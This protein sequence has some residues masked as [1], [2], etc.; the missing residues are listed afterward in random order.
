[1]KIWLLAFAF[2]SL[3]FAFSS[4]SKLN[5]SNLDLNNENL[6][7]VRNQHNIS[8]CYA[9]TGADMLAHE[10]KVNEAISAADVAI[11][12]N[13]TKIALFVRWLD[14]NILNRRDS[15][16][17]SLA[18]QNGFNKVALN[19]AMKDGWCPESI[20]PSEAWPKMSRTERGWVQ[21]QIPLDQAMLEIAALHEKNK[22]LTV[23]NIP[24]YFNLK[25]IDLS[26]FLKILQSKSM[27]TI[28]SSI[29]QTVCRD[30]RHPFEDQRNIKMVFKNSEI[31][32]TIG[33]QLEVGKLVGLDYDSRILKDRNHTGFELNNL[34][35]SSLVG[36]RWNEKKNTCEYLIRNS[37]GNACGNR[38]DPGYDCIS[39]NVWLNESQIFT[40]MTSIV[41]LQSSIERE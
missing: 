28:Y 22:S 33:T 10:Y 9:F 41:Y 20:F 26:M 36:R 24:Y 2:P 15:I 27:A 7:N 3:V 17:R 38:Y 1:M 21:S 30:D 34:H 13:Q 25:N 31:F 19:H 35:T 6:G 12:Y 37:W 23:E 8:W 4:T 18:H 29:R 14:L 32:S 5:C 39:G 16:L 40:S 11:G